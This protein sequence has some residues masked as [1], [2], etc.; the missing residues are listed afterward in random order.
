MNNK[1]RNTLKILQLSDC[2]VSADPETGYRGQNADRNL[3]ALIP[4]MKAW[5]PDRV[6]LSGDISEDASPESY[7]RIA[8][9]LSSLAVPLL[10][11]PGNHDSPSEMKRHFP[12]GPWQGPFAHR[13]GSWLLVMLDS[14]GPGEISGSIAPQ[15][16][17][18]LD[19]LFRADPAE[20]I[21]LA[22]HHQ[23]VPVNAPWID[24]YALQDSEP[25]LELLDRTDRL[26]CVTWGH[27]HQDFQT[28]REGVLML[29]APSSVANSLP[30]TPVFTLD[31][32]GPACR[33]LDLGSDG[34]VKTG[35][36]RPGQSSTG[37]T[38]QRIR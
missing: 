16:L 18:T 30:R 27:I 4:E 31:P 12:L 24:K 13:A 21:L 7:R 5:N 1:Q 29:G 33:W 34:T 20:H 26:R 6:L 9:A 3:R 23:P 22:L 14:T 11:L 25:L 36:L 32:A 19:K 28:T 2:H 15:E 10:A 38:S 17:E 35:V 8:H 37:R